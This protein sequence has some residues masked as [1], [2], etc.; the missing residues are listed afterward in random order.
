MFKKFLIMGLFEDEE[1][2]IDEEIDEDEEGVGDEE[3]M[4]EDGD[5]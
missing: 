3:E 5:G 1:E 2:E 4:G